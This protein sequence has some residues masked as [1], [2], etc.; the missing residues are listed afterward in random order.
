MVRQ[1]RALGQRAPTDDRHRRLFRLT[2]ETI[3]RKPTPVVAGWNWYSAFDDPYRDNAG[4]YWLVEPGRRDWGRV[5]GGHCICLA[6]RAMRDLPAWWRF[7]DQGSE[8]A[9]VGFGTG[10]ALSILNRVRYD[11]FALYHHAQRI[12]E[13]DGEEYDGTSVRAG[14]DVARK[15]GGYPSRAGKTTGPLAQHGIKENRWAL[16]VDDMAA[17]LSSD[18]SGAAVLSQGYVLLKN[19]WGAL[20]Y[21]FEVRVDL[22]TIYRLTFH[23]DGEMTVI[24]DLP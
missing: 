2:D 10:R 20:G 18:D 15:Y 22:D 16:S 5:R 19:S 23:E 13:W 14:M 21:P 11:G 1:E 7:Y 17:C 9:C 4:H 24:T 6:T 8:G 3:P 12:D